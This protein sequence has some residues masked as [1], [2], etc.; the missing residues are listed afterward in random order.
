MLRTSTQL[1]PQ[2]LLGTAQPW[3][4]FSGPLTRCCYS[5]LLELEDQ[6]HR[7]LDI[8]GNVQR[9]LDIGGT[10]QRVLDIGGNDQRLLDIG[11]TVQISRLVPLSQRL[12]PAEGDGQ[13]SEP[14]PPGAGSGFYL[15][16]TGAHLDPQQSVGAAQPWHIYP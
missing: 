6:S 13:W 10:V 3:H 16:R 8:G 2:H 12:R 5:C 14:R 9:L 15:A 4:I 1:D 7:F 11:G